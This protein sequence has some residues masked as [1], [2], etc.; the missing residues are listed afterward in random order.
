MNF[1]PIVEVK[2][3]REYKQRKKKRVPNLGNHIQIIKNGDKHHNESWNT[4]SKKNIANFPSP[5]RICLLGPCGTGKTMLIKNLIMAQRPMFDEVFLV[6]EDAG[7]TDDYKGFDLTAEFDDMP[8]LDFWDYDGK[9]K[10]R[11]LIIDDLELTSAHKE[12]KKNLAIAFRYAST[13]KG[14]TIYFAHQSFFSI[15]PLVKKMSNV[16]ILWKPRARNELAMIENRVG[17]EKG[18]LK[19]LFKTEAT[20]HRDSICIDLNE[21]TPARVRKN[22]WEEIELSDSD[23]DSD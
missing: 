1:Q 10:K 7:V 20:G 4:K 14:L 13:H 2:E 19:K 5:S 21:G 6:H 9:F 8:D 22:I 11:A 12:R 15:M 18:T 17:M 23:S 16:F 3:K